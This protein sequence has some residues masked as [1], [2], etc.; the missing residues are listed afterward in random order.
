[1]PP[2]KGCGFVQFYLKQDSEYAIKQMQ[3]FECMGCS[4]RTHWGRSQSECTEAMFRQLN[5]DFTRRPKH[6]D[7]AGS[8]ARREPGHLRLRRPRC[9]ERTHRAGLASTQR[10]QWLRNRRHHDTL[11]S[12]IE[13]VGGASFLQSR[14]WVSCV[15]ITTHPLPPPPSLSP[16]DVFRN[17]P[18]LSTVVSLIMN[19]VFRFCNSRLR[20]PLC[21]SIDRQWRRGKGWHHPL[22]QTPVSRLAL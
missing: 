2:G 21:T 8:G 13:V 6:A 1:M 14:L 16:R 5:A 17:I 20:W 3:G 18:F 22:C 19:D 10:V 4:L 12:L 15:F 11:V 9:T 7:H